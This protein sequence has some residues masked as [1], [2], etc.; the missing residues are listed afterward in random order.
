M[1]LEDHLHVAALHLHIAHAHTILQRALQIVLLH[2]LRILYVHHVRAKV[3]H[4]LGR[5]C[6][7][8][9]RVVPRTTTRAA[10]APAPAAEAG[11]GPALDV[12]LLR[13]LVQDA[14][15]DVR[16]GLADLLAH[17]RRVHRVVHFV[18]RLLQLALRPLVIVHHRRCLHCWHCWRRLCVVPGRLRRLAHALHAAPDQ[19]VHVL[20]VGEDLLRHAAKLLLVG[21]ARLVLAPLPQQRVLLQD[22]HVPRDARAL[23]LQLLQLHQLALANQV[24]LLV[25]LVLL[26]VHLC[27]WRCRLFRRRGAGVRVGRAGVYFREAVVQDG[28]VRLQRLLR[29]CGRGELDDGGVGLGVQLRVSTAEHSYGDGVDVAE[30]LEVAAEG[31]DLWVRRS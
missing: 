27:C 18:Q 4:Q 13:A 1:L 25:H 20:R 5:V 28:D 29:F 21:N 24:Q 10:S 16:R 14:R 23:A 15:H 8:A 22:R 9:R 26:L 12:H 6:P 30:A 3:Q 31:H 17:R 7:L 19:A 11:E 2:S